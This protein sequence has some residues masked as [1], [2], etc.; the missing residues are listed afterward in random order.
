FRI[1]GVGLRTLAVANLVL[2]ALTTALLHAL[3][4][5]AGA[6]R[7]AAG[8]AALVFLCVFGFGHLILSGS[9]NFVCPYAHEATHGFLLALGALTCALRAADETNAARVSRLPLA[10]G[11][12]CGLA[13]L[14]KPESFAAG[15]VACALALWLG[16]RG[17]TRSAWIASAGVFT[18]GLLLPAVLATALLARALPAEEALRGTLGSWAYLGNA[19]LLQL[20]YFAWSMGLD[21]PGDHLRRMAVACGRLLMVLGP[22]AGA[23]WAL[24]GRTLARWTIP[25]AGLLTLAAL[26]PFWRARWWFEIARPL[27]LW[28]LGVLIGAAVALRR[29]PDAAAARAATARLALAVFA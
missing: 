26:A 29:S 14:T 10:S 22:A 8:A 27:P 12:L 7:L 24:R 20:R 4:R 18:F 11:L 1:C 21:D 19:D 5:R 2:L 17:W 15:L 6:G 16:A 3:L 25:A 23:A 13:F 9:F 28:T